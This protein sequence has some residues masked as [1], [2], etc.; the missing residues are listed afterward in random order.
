MTSVLAIFNNYSLAC[1][2]MGWCIAQ[3]LKF[4][5]NLIRFHKVSVSLLISSGGMPSSHSATVCA[6]AVSV[7]RKCG[8]GSELFA[9]A[10]I[11]AFIV[12]YD[13]AGVRR[14]AGEQAKK[15]NKLMRDLDDFN[16]DNMGRELKELLGHTPLEVTAG[17][18][19]GTLIPF[20]LRVF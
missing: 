6:L 16:T 18:L 13:A 15:I 1:A 20:V 2:A 8:F 11:L 3:F 5:I 17:A 14:A 7:G 19:L 4:L 9:I 12:M 10:F